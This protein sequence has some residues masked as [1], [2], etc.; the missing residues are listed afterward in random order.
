MRSPPSPVGAVGKDDREWHARPRP[1]R[2]N[3]RRVRRCLRWDVLI[4]TRN[5]NE[6]LGVGSYATIGEARELM[7]GAVPPG[8]VEGDLM[9]MERGTSPSSRRGFAHSSSWGR[10]EGQGC[11][12]ANTLVKRHIDLLKGNYGYVVVDNEAGM[13]HMSR[14]VTQDVDHLFVISD[15]TSRGI[16]TA[17]RILGV[18]RELKPRV[19]ATH[20][21]VVNRVRSGRGKRTSPD[22]PGSAR[23]RWA[24]SSMMTHRFSRWRRRAA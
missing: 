11:Y 20:V 5:S 17:R 18:C 1:G 16:M 12:C 13:E 14:L 15:P 22:S 7:K 8:H 24:A 6:V 23:S 9:E 21:A 3:P 10:P 4:P 2:R 19:G